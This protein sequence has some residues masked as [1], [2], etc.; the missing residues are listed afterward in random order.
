MAEVLHS[1]VVPPVARR[2]T[3]RFVLAGKLPDDDGENDYVD[4]KNDN[5]NQNGENNEDDD[6]Y[7]EN[8]DDEPLL[9]QSETSTNPL[10]SPPVPV[11]DPY[12]WMRDDERTNTEVLQHIAAENE[13]TKQITGGNEMIDLRS[14]LYDEM[15]DRLQETDYSC[16]SI[17][18]GLTNS[19]QYWYYVRT[20]E[21]CSYSVFCRAPVA[22]SAANQGGQYDAVM[23]IA[24]S[25][26]GSPTAP[27]LPGEVQYLNVNVLASQGKDGKP[28]EYCSVGE[29]EESPSQSLIAYTLDV[30]GDEV[31]KLF[32]ER[33]RT[34][35]HAAPSVDAKDRVD[36]S[37][38]VVDHDANLECDGTV[39]WSNDDSSLFYVEMDDTLRS[40]K[41]RRRSLSQNQQKKLEDDEVIYEEKDE[42]FDVGIGKTSDEKYLLVSTSSAETSEV[43]YLS[44]E[45]DNGTSTTLRC[46]AKRQVKVLYD[47]DHWNGNW[48]ITS[49]A[50]G[51]TNMKLLTSPV[52]NVNSSENES[53]SPHAHWKDVAIHPSPLA[54][55]EQSLPLFDGGPNRALESIVA[56]QNHVV[57]Y[58]REGG[59]PRIWILKLQQEQSLTP[60]DNTKGENDASQ[61]SLPP[62]QVIGF[63][64]LSL[65]ND[66]KI[67]ENEDI[68]AGFDIGLGPNHQYNTSDLIIA[69]DSPT[70][71]PQAI[72]VNMNDYFN[73]DNGTAQ[74]KLQLILKKSVVPGYDPSQY[75]SHREFVLSR[76]GK[77]RIPV[78]LVYHKNITFPP[79]SPDNNYNGKKSNKVHPLHLYGYGSYGD[80]CEC[81]FDPTRLPLLDRGIIYA[82]VHVRGGGEMGR[83]WYEDPKHGGKYLSKRNTFFD[84]IDVASHYSTG[85]S[86]ITDSSLLS[87]EGRS[88]GGLLIG[89][90]INQEPEL[91]KCA[92]LGVPFVDVLCSMIDSTIPL[93][94]GEWEEWG[95][96][97]EE[98]FFEYMKG[99]DPMR[100]VKI[101]GTY[102]SCLLTGGL[103]DSRVQYW[104]PLKFAAELR[105]A[106]DSHKS[107]PVCLKME[108]SAGHFSASDRYKYLKEL[109]FDYAF[110]L[111]QLG[112]VMRRTKQGEEENPV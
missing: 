70:E 82:I 97:N 63:A 56:F 35:N 77:N 18:K 53:S 106:Q 94:V 60:S 92:I 47:I 104:E 88:A 55:E 37:S 48:L 49:N 26:D 108:M 39:V 2:D 76:D 27:I 22:D 62:L 57:A 52:N 78:T 93:T 50:G 43:H 110:L 81:D 87:I 41:V 89:A 75:S 71:P 16:P 96:P 109:A 9:R 95:N 73:E 21:G 105:H 107:G 59:L 8:E 28:H 83:Q 112:L 99:Y 98:Y 74:Q 72:V 90:A 25:W 67:K 51:S 20:M 10:I 34:N 36:S 91:F 64:Q 6:D 86:K 58:G 61:L 38:L 54:V 30:V 101:D 24:T 33:M 1:S 100:N 85:E 12:G 80:S 40:Y 103:H 11:P 69:Y 17:I 4:V 79:T 5:G 3:D 31:Y 44:L 13:F 32:V 65:Q 7:D 46:V 29:M 111:D 23:D 15:K 14:K 102:P 68:K 84:F 66:N 19:S 42:L 45:D